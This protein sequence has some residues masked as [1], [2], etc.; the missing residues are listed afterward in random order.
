MAHL[1]GKRK[2]L[3]QMVWG[4]VMNL[5]MNRPSL[6]SS[7]PWRF[8]LYSP[9]RLAM[10]GIWISW[11][12]PTLFYMA[13][14]RRMSSG[15]NP[16]DSLTRLNRTLF[17]IYDVLSTVLNN[18]P[19]RGSTNCET[20]LWVLVSRRVELM[21]PSLYFT[22]QILSHTFLCMSMIS[23][24][25][26]RHRNSFGQ[27]LCLYPL[28][29]RS[30]ISVSCVNFWAFMST[31]RGMAPY[32]SPRINMCRIFWSWSIWLICDLPALRRNRG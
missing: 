23:S 15:G 11:T 13:F 28:N 2:D 21:N 30:K 5:T 25:L 12:Y 32:F 20:L 1:F 6:P 19:R 9:W 4:S 17:A 26:A 7:R 14:S 27:Y 8:G 10:D 24:S 29:S 31:G 3:W 16:P 18:L 22:Y